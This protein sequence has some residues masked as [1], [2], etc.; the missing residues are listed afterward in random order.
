MKSIKKKRNILFFSS[1]ILA[2][3][4]FS[5]EYKSVN[6]VKGLAVGSKVKMFSTVDQSGKKYQLS[7]ALQ[8]GPVVLLFYRGQWCPVCNRYLSKLQDSLQ[9]IYDKGATVIAVS[10]EKP[11]NLEKTASKTKA[12]FTLLYD[13]DYA[14]SEAFDVVFKPSDMEI[15][16]YDD[17]LKADLE[18]A[19]TDT[20][21]RLPVSATFIIDKNGIVVW[22][23]FN[24]DYRIRASV[25]DIL[26]HIPAKQN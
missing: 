10:P 18:H 19:N 5:Q 12:T 20:T 8:K 3:T 21:K 23:H 11:E 22:R 4:S 24:P 16:M 7:R 1:L 9:Q 2:L 13:K 14:I 26:E 15:A 6:E 17:R 25:A